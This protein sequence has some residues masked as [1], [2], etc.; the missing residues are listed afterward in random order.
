MMPAIAGIPVSS[1]IEHVRGVEEISQFGLL[2][3]PALVIN[4]EIKAVGSMPPKIKPKVWIQEAANRK[5]S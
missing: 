5:Q 3:V 2:R 4:S 1:M